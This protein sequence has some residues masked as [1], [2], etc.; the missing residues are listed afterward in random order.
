MSAETMTEQKIHCYRVWMKDGYC[1]LY[2]AATEADARNQ[3]IEQA[4]TTIEG[5]HMSP[6]EKSKAVAIGHVEKLS[7]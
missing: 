3:A 6:A 2:N 7:K 4:K 1:G 5:V